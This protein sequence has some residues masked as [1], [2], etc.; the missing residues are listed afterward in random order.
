MCFRRLFLCLLVLS[1]VL[2][3]RPLLVAQT[4]VSQGSIQGTVTDS[5]GAVVGGATITIT[6]KGTGQVITTTST[7]SGT[8]NSGGLIPGDYVLRVEAK[9][10]R[11][12][13]RAFA[14]QVGVTSSGNMK[15]EVGEASQV[16]EVQ[17]SSIQVNTEQEPYKAS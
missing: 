16:V 7:N 2:L 14:V 15:L 6:H 3:T 9:G 4:T 5:S 12:A 1:A 13:E 11:T 17:A 8:F 10:F